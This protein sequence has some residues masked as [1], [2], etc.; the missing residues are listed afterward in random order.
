MLFAYKQITMKIH[1]VKILCVE[2]RWLLQ[3]GVLKKTQ[4]GVI[5]RMLFIYNA[6]IQYMI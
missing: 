3:K 1:Q 6:D 2:A 4:Q 5:F